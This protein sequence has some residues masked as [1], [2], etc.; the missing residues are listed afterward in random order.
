MAGLDLATEKIYADGRAYRQDVIGGGEYFADHIEGDGTLVVTFM[1]LGSANLPHIADEPV[2][3][4]RPLFKRGMS[5]LG[6]KPAKGDWYRGPSLHGYLR[7]QSTARFLAGFDRVIFYGG[8]MGGYAALAFSEARPGAEIIAYCPQTTMARSLVGEWENRWSIPAH[9]R[10]WEGDFVDGAACAAAAS[11][12]TVLYDSMIREDRNHVGRLPRARLREVVVP[13]TGHNTMVWL[14][15][16]GLLKEVLDGLLDDTLDFSTLRSKMKRR[17]EL[18]H[19]YVELMRS[20]RR[21]A[22]KEFCQRKVE[23]L[24]AKAIPL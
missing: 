1:P 9:S 22:V 7:A 18:S 3:A 19:Y 23:E 8:S 13:F 6:I 21:P 10:S 2:W 16:M 12:I 11:K 24:A 20:S 15:R 5:V 4:G 17:R 14:G